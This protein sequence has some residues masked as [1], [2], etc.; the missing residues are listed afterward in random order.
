VASS[1]AG[2]TTRSETHAFHSVMAVA[3]AT[4]TTL[5]PKMAAN[6]TA[7][8]RALARVSTCFVF[9]FGNN[10]LLCCLTWEQVDSFIA[11]SVW[12]EKVLTFILVN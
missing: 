6:I 3:R 2:A 7:R 4:R 1:H 9:V 8:S 5:P 11:F 10:S 12:F